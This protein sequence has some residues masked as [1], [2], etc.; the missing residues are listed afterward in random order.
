MMRDFG[1]VFLAITLVGLVAVVLGLVLIAVRRD[2][3]MPWPAATVS[4][5]AGE[6]VAPPEPFPRSFARFASGLSGR[7]EAM[8]ATR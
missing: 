8:V 3:A 6:F 5:L 7:I 2:T 1:T 4:A